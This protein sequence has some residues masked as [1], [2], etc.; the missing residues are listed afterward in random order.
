MKART[1][2]TKPGSEISKPVRTRKSATSRRMR[3]DVVHQLH[4]FIADLS[5]S[6]QF[7]E[8]FILS[9]T[10]VH[11]VCKDQDWDT[12]HL[13]KVMEDVWSDLSESAVPVM[14]E[15]HQN[16]L[17]ENCEETGLLMKAFLEKEDPCH[18]QVTVKAPWLLC[19]TA[20]ILKLIEGLPASKMGH[21]ESNPARFRRLAG[22]VCHYICASLTCSIKQTSPAPSTS[23]K[24][25]SVPLKC[26][27]IDL[28]LFS[29]HLRVKSS[30]IHLPWIAE[31]TMQTFHCECLV[32][33]SIFRY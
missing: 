22:Q 27:G 26:L 5:N 30:V 3:N 33:Q 8:F 32:R 25:N 31:I 9:I 12:V 11:W 17:E 18:R 1:S 29:M 21:R 4:Y 15:F 14:D 20:N 24:H 13:A 10:F 28:Q 2:Q 6:I 16:Y 7:N 19:F 23:F